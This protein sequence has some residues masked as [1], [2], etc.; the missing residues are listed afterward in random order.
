MNRKYLLV[1][2]TIVLSACAAPVK[3]PQ[4]TEFLSDYARLNEVEREFLAYA[5]DRV[6]DYDRF[7]IE[8]VV[9]L[10]DPE[11]GGKVE[12]TDEELQALKQFIHDKLSESLTQGNSGYRIVDEPG[13]GVALIR[14]SI[15]DLHETLGALNVSLITKA[16]GAGLGG[17]CTEAEL[18]DSMSGEQLAAAVR[19]GSGSRVLRA[20]FT[21]TGDAKILIVRW[22]KEIR[23]YID[24]LNSVT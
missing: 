9:M 21:H 24:H 2:A 13:P 18:V 17:V 14:I 15:H 16:T 5:G 22:A 11:K 7:L 20:G 8:P 1:I 10:Y 4:Q 3:A 6:G 19:W 12:F 23:E